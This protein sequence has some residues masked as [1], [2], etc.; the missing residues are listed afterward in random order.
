VIARTPTTGTDADGKIFAEASATGQGALTYLWVQLSAGAPF[1]VGKGQPRQSLAQAP[2]G[3]D[4]GTFRLFVGNAFGLTA[5]A[6]FTPNRFVDLAS[7]AVAGAGDGVLI[8][9]FS[10][11]GGDPGLPR[12]RTMLIRAVGPALGAFGVTSV[13]Q[14]PRLSLFAGSQLVAT[15]QGWDTNANAAAIRDAAQSVGAFPLPAGAADSALL[16][17]LAQGNYT[18]QVTSA[19]GTPGVALVEVY[20]TD[21]PG[22]SRLKNLST[23]AQVQSGAG[24]LIGGLVIDGG[25]KR[26]VLLRAAGPA[27]AIFG[28]QGV[29]A[30]PR[31]TLFK[32]GAVVATAAEWGSATNV[33]AIRSATTRV[34]AFAFPDGSLDAAM[35]LALDPGVYSLQVTGADGG[36]GV[37]LIEVYEAP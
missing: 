7:R 16:L 6:A 36:T 8:A 10:I 4:G 1:P 34:N 21:L 35:L 27:L 30:K 19:D 23:R 12:S 2:L 14:A 31:L 24:V 3:V 28:V 13:L 9:G 22:L 33:D 29:L 26:S 32:D 18:A 20:D 17:T 5:S 37:A 15:N 25:V 11:G